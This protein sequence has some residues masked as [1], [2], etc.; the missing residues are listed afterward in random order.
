[1]SASRGGLGYVDPV[2]AGIVQQMNE[3]VGTLVHVAR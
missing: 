2:P 1:V 3:V